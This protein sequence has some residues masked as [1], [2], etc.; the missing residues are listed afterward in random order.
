[1]QAFT[2]EAS[3]QWNSR[4][5]LLT[6]CILFCLLE[7]ESHQMNPHKL[8]A[9]QHSAP[10]RLPEDVLIN[11]QV[12]NK[13]SWSAP[14]GAH[15]FSSVPRC[16]HLSRAPRRHHSCLLLWAHISLLSP[17]MSGGTCSPRTRVAVAQTNE[18]ARC[19][20]SDIFLNI[21]KLSCHLWLEEE[22]GFLPG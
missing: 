11:C 22:R 4:K 12:K 19:L 18:S 1:M 3:L 6:I 5:A 17:T 10:H 7:Q 8:A 20:C 21:N 13:N 9:L 16:H 14:R 2:R 15:S